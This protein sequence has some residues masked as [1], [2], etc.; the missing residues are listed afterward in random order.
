MHRERDSILDL[1]G[2]GWQNF[3]NSLRFNSDSLIISMNSKHKTRWDLFVMVLATYNC[4][5]IPLEI[6]FESPVLF[7]SPFRILN[8]IID[9][10]FL[11]DL[12]LSFRTT[13]L[14]TRSGL[15]VRQGKLLAI[16]YLK[17]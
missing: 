1:L 3:R 11:I 13:Y 10:I 8:G 4:Y 9:F 17:G 12:L 16:Y 15:E 6:A 2:N 7:S 5:E 14:D